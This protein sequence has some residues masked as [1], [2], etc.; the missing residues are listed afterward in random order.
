MQNPHSIMHPSSVLFLLK[1]TSK[2]GNVIR[3]NG[4]HNKARGAGCA[5]GSLLQIRKLMEVKHMQIPS[6]DLEA[7]HTSLFQGSFWPWEI[8]NKFMNQAGDKGMWIKTRGDRYGYA[9]NAAE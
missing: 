5:S 9:I 6:F 7:G 8:N 3:D 4:M 1:I 2:E